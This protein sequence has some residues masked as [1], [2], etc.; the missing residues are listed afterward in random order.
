MPSIINSEDNLDSE[1]LLPR[2]DQWCKMFQSPPKPSLLGRWETFQ[3]YSGVSFTP[4][5]SVVSIHSSFG[6]EDGLIRENDPVQE[7]RAKGNL[8]K[9]VLREVNL[10]YLIW[11][12]QSLH[13]VRS[14]IFVTFC[15]QTLSYGDDTDV[16][17][18]GKPSQYCFG[19]SSMHRI[20]CSLSTLH[21]LLRFVESASA[22]LKFFSIGPFVWGRRGG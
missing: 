6:M 5:S 12:F 16:Q 4:V 17:I 9:H 8:I 10:R 7:I 11:F 15:F 13:N 2:L 20:I 21:N 3:L 14:I 1:L 19:F 22:S 18:V